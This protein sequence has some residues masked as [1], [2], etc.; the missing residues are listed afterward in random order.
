M[1]SWCHT[2]HEEGANVH[3]KF[4]WNGFRATESIHQIQILQ[5]FSKC[6]EIEET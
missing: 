1:M 4:N 2:T 6:L 3:H 5:I